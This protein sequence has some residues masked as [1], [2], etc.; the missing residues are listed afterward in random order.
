MDRQLSPLRPVVKTCDDPGRTEKSRIR[1]LAPWTV[2][3]PIGGSKSGARIVLNRNTRKW[4][5]KINRGGPR[6]VWKCLVDL[7][8][9]QRDTTTR[10]SP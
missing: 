1:S 5:V 9:G 6:A 2:T 8:D 3:G 7:S 4:R 10:Y